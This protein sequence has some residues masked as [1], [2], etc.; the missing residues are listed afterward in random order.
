MS[1]LRD[2]IFDAVTDAIA[3]ECPICGLTIT[4]GRTIYNALVRPD[5]DPRHDYPCPHCKSKIKTQLRSN[6]R[7]REHRPARGGSVAKKLARD[8]RSK[9]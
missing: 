9:I 1:F 2:V 4:I 8:R 5:A 3:A 7:K 6:L